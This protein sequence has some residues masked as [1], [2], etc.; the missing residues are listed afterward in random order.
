M[1]LESTFTNPRD[2]EGGEKSEDAYDR[3]GYLRKHIGEIEDS[4]KGIEE[5]EKKENSCGLITFLLQ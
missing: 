4:F 3:P 1:S 5:E 2:F